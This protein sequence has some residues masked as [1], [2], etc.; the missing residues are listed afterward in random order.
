VKPTFVVAICLAFLLP[1]SSAL[2]YQDV[3]LDP[4]DRPA[5]GYDPDIRSTGRV[6]SAT[7]QGVRWLRVGFRA[8]EPLGVWWFV[9]VYIDSKGGP[10]AD[11][12]MRLA[13]ADLSGKGCDI[14][15][16]G[17]G[18]ADRSKG[19]FRQHGDQA[20]CSVRL[21]RL[22]HTK[23]IRWRL[24]SPSG[25]DSPGKTDIAPNGGGWYS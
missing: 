8:Y 3:R 14:S 9:N 21:S 7:A 25:Y 5:V 6:V 19:R 16:V 1:A 17:G 24:V 10:Q 12:L 22:V 11:Y 4:N 15:P 2:A 13:N 23:R 20:T 18:G